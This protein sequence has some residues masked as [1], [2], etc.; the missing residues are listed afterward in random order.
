MSIKG[1]ITAAGIL[2]FILFIFLSL[3]NLGFYNR[4]ISDIENRDYAD[5]KLEEIEEFQKWK[6]SLVRELSD[7]L[8][9]VSVSDTLDSLLK[10]EIRIDEKTRF[11]I[12]NAENLAE[13]IE[14]KESA[15]SEQEEKKQFFHETINDLYNRLDKE[16]S[17]ALARAQM[18]QVLGFDNTDQNFLAPY[19]LKSLNQLTVLALNSLISMEYTEQNQSIVER[20]KKFLNSQVYLIDTENKIKVLFDEL[21]SQINGINEYIELTDNVF[22]MIDLQ[23]EKASADFFSAVELTETESEIRKTREDLDIANKNLEKISRRSFVII[24]IFLLTI[25]TLVVFLGIW[26]LNSLIIAPISDL[27]KVMEDFES[28]NYNSDVNIH[29]RDEIGKLGR[30][31]NIMAGEINNKI[32]QLSELNNELR[33]SE[34]KYRIL[35]DNLPQAIFLKNLDSEY[36]SCN[37]NFAHLLNTPQEEILGKTDLDFYPPETAGKYRKYDTEVLKKG[38]GIQ[39]EECLLI[40][41]KEISML[42]NKIPIHDEKGSIN[43]VLGISWDITEIKENEHELEKLV[44]E[45][46]TLV[47]EIHHRVKNNMSMVISLI[48]LKASDLKNAEARQILIDSQNRIRSMALI[49]EKL[50]LSDNIT[51]I[52]A[53]EYITTFSAELLDSL[54]YF[55]SRID[56]AFDIDDLLL[57]LSPLIYIGL[58]INE[59]VTNSIKYAFKNIPD[60]Q[61]EIKLKKTGRSEMSLIISDNGI[62]INVEDSDSDNPIGLEI[63]DM[64]IIQLNASKEV[65]TENG[66][67]YII[68]IPLNEKA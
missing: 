16:I 56:L 67:K 33:E 58:L 49:H 10:P 35:V 23:L 13:T 46:E 1:K 31:F 65:Y 28:G 25:P 27:I 9:S 22:R 8:V 18:N 68:R 53:K 7:S 51:L 29:T 38:S 57:E 24:V 62:G 43:G 12:E 55:D 6:T 60:P 45:R 64:L 54:N 66:T 63:I 52:E 26:G 50:Y 3:V 11:L 39:R 59:A 30:A 36:I 2:I 19:V 34:A 32:S 17:T 15:I 14:K 4:I 21:Y 41:N 44:E 48:N 37:R 42:T 47:H 20:N 5:K 40:D 61:I